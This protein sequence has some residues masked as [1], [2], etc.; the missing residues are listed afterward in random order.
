MV[1]GATGAIGTALCTKLL[2]E[3]F[4]V[5][6]VCRRDSRRES[7]IPLGAKK[8]Y[9]DLNELLSL[10]QKIEKADVFYHL[11]WANTVGSGR[12][13]MFSQTENIKHTLVAVNVAKKLG[14]ECFIG[15]GSQAEYGRS[16][17]PLRSNTPCFPEN[18]YGMAKLCAGL[19]SRKTCAELG[20]RHIWARILSVY[21][22]F[23]SE[24]S[25]ISKAVR[26]QKNGETLPLTLGEQVWDY[27]FSYDAAEALYLMFRHGRNGAVYPLGGG[28]ARPLYE[29]I[30]EIREA[31]PGNGIF[32]FGE[33]PYGK[34]QV[35]YLR[36]DVTDIKN[37]LGFSPKYTFKE[38]IRITAGI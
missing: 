24:G 13:D 6:A 10:S 12:N 7:N 26:A 28:T 33:I 21:G 2:D 15:A 9:C 27:L 1:T 20:M 4:D 16:S 18:G 5:Y 25:L 37:D 36:A 38:G 32:K 23:D 22:P 19:M 31:I 30:K 8:V 14:C 11:G 34:D 17:E 29:Y 35:M 3:G